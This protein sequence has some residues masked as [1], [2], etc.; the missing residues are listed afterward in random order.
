[1]CKCCTSRSKGG[2][3]ITRAF[4]HHLA[5]KETAGAHLLTIHNV[6]FIL[7]LIDRARTAIIADEFPSFVKV[8]FATLYDEI[9][10]YPTWAVDALRK[11][12][13]DLMS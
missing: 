3:G 7:Q 11:V 5:A 2:F 8:F 10:K 1:M 9:E 6:H 4:I 13:V 12:G